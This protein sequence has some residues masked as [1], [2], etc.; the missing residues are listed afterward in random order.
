M[1]QFIACGILTLLGAALIG[2]M[3][4]LS[5]MDRRQF[6]K[7]AKFW[8]WVIVRFVI[9]GALLIVAVMSLSKGVELQ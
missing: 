5:I 9:A 3:T 7:P 1:P 8:M 4:A 6:P 2:A